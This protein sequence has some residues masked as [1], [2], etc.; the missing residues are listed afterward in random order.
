MAT[1]DRLDVELLSRLMANARAGV[2]ELAS[3]L[4]VSRTTVQH[5]LRRLEDEGILVGFQPIIN[6]SVI[7]LPVQALVSLEIDQR[8]MPTIIDG[9]RDLPEVLEVKIQAGREDLL[10]HVA[11]ASLEELQRLTAAIVLLDGVRKTTSTFTVS[12]PIPHRVL[13]LL[14]DVTRDAGW[15][16]STPAP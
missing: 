7:G 6:L 2:A 12:T 14:S 5:R 10:V 1:I 3:D 15:G 4:G 13:P 16:R 11:I 9:L 8:E